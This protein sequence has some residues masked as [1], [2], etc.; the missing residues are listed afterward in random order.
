MKIT[1]KDKEFLEN[2]I[3]G[4]IKNEVKKAKEKAW[5]ENLNNIKMD[6]EIEKIIKK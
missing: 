4:V 6:L 5:L 2:L 3:Y 1:K